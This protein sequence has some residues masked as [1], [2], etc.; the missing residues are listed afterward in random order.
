MK[1]NKNRVWRNYPMVK[2]TYC[3]A[4]DPGSVSN[5]YMVAHKHLYLKLQGIQ[6]VPSSSTYRDLH[7]CGTQT[8][9]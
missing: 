4:E 7:I 3:F 9:M 6:S 5:I 2:S 8:L 1:N